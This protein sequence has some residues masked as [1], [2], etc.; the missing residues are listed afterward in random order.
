MDMGLIISLCCIAI[1]AA[2]FY[3]KTK[4]TSVEGVIYGLRGMKVILQTVENTVVMLGIVKREDSCFD[5][6]VAVIINAINII[7]HSLKEDD[8]IHETVIKEALEIIDTLNIDLSE[9][10]RQSIVFVIEMGCSIINN[11][12][13][14]NNVR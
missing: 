6:V 2:M 4:L 13:G 12:V 8:V 11:F 5:E 9:D 10:K 14:K 7:K 1:V 3:A